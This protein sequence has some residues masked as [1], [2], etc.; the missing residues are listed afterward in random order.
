MKH[1]W[2]FSG[3]VTRVVDA[4]TYDITVDLGFDISQ[5][6]RFRLVALG[7]DFDAPETWRPQYESERIHGEAANTLARELVE[8]K[9][10]I[11]KSVRRGK[12]RYVA[13]IFFEDDDGIVRDLAEVLID[14]GFQKLNESEYIRL[15]EELHNG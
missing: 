5:N 4:D 6:T 11:I 13:T 9:Q 8:G 7:R 15:D 14:N 1:E 12:Y 3:V 10:V 2:I